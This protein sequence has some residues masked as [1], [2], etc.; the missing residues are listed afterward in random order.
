MSLPS[1]IEQ[2]VALLR[3]V[4]ADYQPE[5]AGDVRHSQADNTRAKEW[6]GY[7][8]L[9]GLEE[10]LQKTIEWWKNSRFAK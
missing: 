1:K 4:A 6:L 7:E 9:V 10:G 3:Q 8:K 2:S 5:R